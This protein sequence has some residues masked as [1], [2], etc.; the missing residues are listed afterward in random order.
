[1]TIELR[2]PRPGEEIEL[3]ELFTEAFGD[4]G[5]TDLFF[6][7]GYSPSRCLGAYDGELLAALH[8]FDCTLDGEK[9]AKL[10]AVLA[11]HRPVIRRIQLPHHGVSQ[12]TAFITSGSP[13]IFIFLCVHGL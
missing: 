9:A 13:D 6:G 5:F 2:H 3:R 10:A 7:R 8:W 11:V 1:M 12:L 4:E